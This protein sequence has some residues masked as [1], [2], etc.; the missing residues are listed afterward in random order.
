MQPIRQKPDQ[1][2]PIT[3]LRLKM[4]VGWCQVEG[5]VDVVVQQG[6]FNM[7]N[8]ESQSGYHA[9]IVIDLVKFD[10][11]QA[12]LDAAL[13]RRGK[14]QVMIVGRR[15]VMNAE[16]LPYDYKGEDGRRYTVKARLFNPTWGKQ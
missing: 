14:L 7:E 5:V 13:E 6:T 12:A 4:D 9:D 10:D 3:D 16:L 11:G 1:L 8:G 15:K 2:P